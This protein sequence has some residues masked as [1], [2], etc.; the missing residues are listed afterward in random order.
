MVDVYYKK[1]YEDNMRYVLFLCLL[2]TFTSFSCNES[3][4]PVVHEANVIWTKDIAHP[5]NLVQPV[6]ENGFVYVAV[7]KTI[8]CFKLD[9]GTLIWESYLGQNSYPIASTKLLHSGRI[10]FLNHKNLVKA[11]DKITGTLV[12]EK[13]F[14]NFNPIN[15]QIMSQNSSSLVV[16]GQGEVIKISKSSGAIELR[17]KLNELVP[18]GYIQLAYNPIIT[19]DGYIYVP[20]G[21]AWYTGNGSKGNILC[22][23]ANTG[24]FIWGYEIPTDFGSQSCAVKDTFIVFP[25]ATSMFA[26]NRFTGKKLWQTN[27]YDGMWESVTIEG[28]TVYMGSTDQ[29]RMYAFDLRTGKLKWKSESTRSSI[30]TIITV[31]NGRVYFCNFAYIYVLNASN[32]S[33]IWKGLPPEYYQDRS[34]LYSSPVAVGEGYMVDVGSRKIYCLTDP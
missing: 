32:G 5:L 33:V 10:L 13:H 30:I 17:I 9:N 25:S 18:A 26:L 20:T 19:D 14:E 4:S 21:I 34:Y 31:T 22:Y 28:E 8:K 11:F 1:C 2:T 27:V 15:L 7:D 3:F 23:N 12:W 16:G 24:E 29:A 6:I